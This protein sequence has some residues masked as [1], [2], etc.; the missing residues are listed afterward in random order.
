MSWLN[1]N[2]LSAW[3]FIFN[4][5]AKASE[6]RE[7]LFCLKNNFPSSKILIICYHYLRSTPCSSMTWLQVCVLF[8]GKIMF[9]LLK[10]LA[11]VTVSKYSIALHLE[12]KIQILIY[13]SHW[14]DNF[15]SL[16]Q[17]FKWIFL[18]LLQLT[19]NP[20]LYSSNLPQAYFAQESFVE[21]IC[22]QT[23]FK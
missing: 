3:G 14:N 23:S 11:F 9:Y 18:V 15:L 16:L 21:N 5:H 13:A 17:T 12:T 8:M 7:N 2:I 6:Q 4:F 20:C 10:A 1:L 19:I 22:F